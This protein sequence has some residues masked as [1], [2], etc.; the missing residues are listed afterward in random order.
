MNKKVNLI[1]QATQ[2]FISVEA[3]IKERFE[4]EIVNHYLKDL[5]EGTLIRIRHDFDDIVSNAGFYLY[6]TN[7]NLK[8]LK[9]TETENKITQV[10]LQ[11]SE[12]SEGY[13]YKIYY[14]EN[15]LPFVHHQ[16]LYTISYDDSEYYTEEEII[17]IIQKEVRKIAKEINV[18]GTIYM[19]I[20]FIELEPL[21]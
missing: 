15:N 2:T 18:S 20:P 19:D 6:H 13:H 5:D 3:L 21:N 7:Q 1:D 14:W 4:V 8:S 10:T 12:A 11:W 17:P 9:I 16:V